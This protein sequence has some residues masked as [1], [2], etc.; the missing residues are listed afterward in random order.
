MQPDPVPF[1]INNHCHITIFRTDLCLRYHDGATCIY[2]P[3]ENYL[4]IRV[5]VE[6]NERTVG[7]RGLMKSAT[8]YH[9]T[10]YTICHVGD[11]KHSHFNIIEVHGYEFGFKYGLIKIR[12]S[13]QIKGW[14][15]KPADGI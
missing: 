13:F 5:A 7:N 11:G 1:R 4:N 6:I 14:N 3:V 2:H 15:F 10:T 12:G 9:R 8:V